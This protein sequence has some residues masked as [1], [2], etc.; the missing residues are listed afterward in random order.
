MLP[1]PRL[2]S[3]SSIPGD[4]RMV[5]KLRSEARAHPRSDG[6]DAHLARHAECRTSTSRPWKGGGGH[7]RGSRIEV[8][9]SRRRAKRET[10]TPVVR[11][12]LESRSSV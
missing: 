7:A 3:R 9:G 4:R 11:P 6:K 8:G 1:R 5:C 12:I 2:A 10:A